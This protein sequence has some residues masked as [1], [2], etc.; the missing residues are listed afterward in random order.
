MFVEKD[1]LYRRLT[2]FWHVFAALALL[3]VGYILTQNDNEKAEILNR[4]ILGNE[5]YQTLVFLL[6]FAINLGITVWVSFPAGIIMFKTLDR[7]TFTNVQSRLF[8]VYFIIVGVTGF[9]QL[10]V[11]LKHKSFSLSSSN[12]DLLL[13]ACLCVE[14]LNGFLNGCIFGPYMS[15]ILHKKISLEREE[16][17]IPPM[18]GSKLGENKEYKAICK[19]FGMVHGLSTI[20]NLLAFS[21]S[22]YVLYYISLEVHLLAEHCS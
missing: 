19:Q 7:H 16:G 10:V 5:F 12:P 13:L 6:C 22:I 1:S 8:P 4:R 2:R 17:V 9:V 11:A 15:G 18:I 14:V 3:S 20:V 21:G